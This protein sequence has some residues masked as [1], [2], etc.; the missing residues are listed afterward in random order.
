MLLYYQGITQTTVAGIIG[1][2]WNI[3]DEED[4]PLCSSAFYSALSRS[5]SKGLGSICLG[6]LVLGPSLLVSRL[7][8][9][10]RLA[11]LK[12]ARCRNPELSLPSH[13]SHE[14][15]FNDDVITRNIN[16]W[17]YSYIGLYGYSFWDAGFKASELFQARGWT[18]VVSDHLILSSMSLSTVVIG[19][20]TAC[21][22][23][24]VS[25]VDGYS[26]SAMHKPLTSAFL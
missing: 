22:G 4:L 9:F 6:S 18:H 20:S 24:I 26:Y 2:W 15:A 8:T 17:S 23:V 25:E 13:E 10:P 1:H 16:Q 21:L 14:S 5:L 19:V 3:T 7:W 11:Q 12:I